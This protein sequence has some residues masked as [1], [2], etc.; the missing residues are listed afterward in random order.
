MPEKSIEF[1]EYS[2]TDLEILED[3][4]AQVGDL[5]GVL[6]KSLDRKTIIMICLAF[7]WMM[8]FFITGPGGIEGILDHLSHV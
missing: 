3:S 6:R 8:I 1:S 4:V 2:K 5:T 7:S